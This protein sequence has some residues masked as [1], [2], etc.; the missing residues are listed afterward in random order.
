MAIYKLISQ[1]RMT[2]QFFFKKCRFQ[3]WGT[4]SYRNNVRHLVSEGRKHSPSKA[5]SQTSGFVLFDVTKL[6]LSD[7]QTRNLFQIGIGI[8]AQW[9]ENM[10]FWSQQ[11]LDSSEHVSWQASGSTEDGV[12]GLSLRLQTQSESCISVPSSLSCTCAIQWLKNKWVMEVK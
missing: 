2:T 8:F 7:P 12:W 1:I 11:C 10:S 3:E 9:Q 4:R 5:D 6:S